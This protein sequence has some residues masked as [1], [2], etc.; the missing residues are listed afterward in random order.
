MDGHRKK[1]LT[2]SDMVR[3]VLDD[4]ASDKFRKQVPKKLGT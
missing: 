4:T 3:I 1:K 2:E